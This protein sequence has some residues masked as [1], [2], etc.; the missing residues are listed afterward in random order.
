LDRLETGNSRT[1]ALS[2][3]IPRLVE[4]AWLLASIEYGAARIRSGHLIT[5]LFTNEDLARLARESSREFN[6]ISLETLGKHLVD[7]TAASTE[8][9]EA[10]SATAE[11]APEAAPVTA[12]KTR[13]LDQFTIDL[14]ARARK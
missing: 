2:P 7:I 5:A 14:T 10:A 3:R 12:A 11:E 1:P 9:R 6:K 4:S 13:A 8:A